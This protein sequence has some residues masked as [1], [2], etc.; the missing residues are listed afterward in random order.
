MSRCLP[1]FCGFKG[2]PIVG[3][4]PPT[5]AG[6]WLWLQGGSIVLSDGDP[7]DTWP[8]DSGTAN[9]ATA[10]TTQRPLFKT[11]TPI[12]GLPVVRF[13]GSDD[14]MAFI[15]PPSGPTTTFIVGRINVAPASL[16]IACPFVIYANPNNG[17]LCG[18][19]ASTSNWGCFLASSGEL[20][21]PTALVSGTPVL[22]EMTS[23]ASGGTKLYRRGVQKASDSS[24]SAEGLNAL[25]GGDPAGPGAFVDGDI[26]ELVTYTSVLSSP[27]RVLVENYLISKYAL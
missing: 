10:T 21:D 23:T 4:T 27:N 19:L 1:P 17:R 24:A 18:R 14:R 22:L 13:D 11:S 12:N 9:D 6:L 7:V 5:I 26:A 16:Q 2:N 20:Y 25:I 8:D 15:S 3:F